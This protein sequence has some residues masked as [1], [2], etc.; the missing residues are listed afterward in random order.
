MANIEDMNSLSDK[1]LVTLIADREKSTTEWQVAEMAF[2][3]LY[4]RHGVAL[5][6]FLK[7]RT[8]L[9]IGGE[10]VA[11]EI[12]L[13]AWEKIP[14]HFDG[15][16]FR[17]WI[18]QIAKN[19]LVDRFRKRQPASLNEDNDVVESHDPAQVYICQEEVTLLRQCINQLDEIRQ[20]IVKLRLAGEDYRTI[21]ERLNIAY[22]T[23]QTRF[24]RAK[25]LLEDCINKSQEG[26]T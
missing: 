25:Q 6:A 21:S 14:S 23:V 12:W 10:D 20:Q 5:L 22:N 19:L 9:H 8:P 4:D 24:H 18:F 3:I 7:A 17:G 26:T 15:G 1:Q 13:R 2:I 16:H 11:Q